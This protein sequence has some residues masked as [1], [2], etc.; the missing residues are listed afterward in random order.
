MT[1]EQRSRALPKLADY[2]GPEP[3]WLRHFPALAAIGDHAWVSAIL[4]AKER[5]LRRGTSVSREPDFR[6]GFVMLLSGRIRVFTHSA[7]GRE[8][9]LYRVGPGD[10][11]L[12]NALSRL[13]SPPAWSALAITEEEV[14]LIAI[15]AK[16]F[17]RAFAESGAFR[18]FVCTQ[19][20]THVS[21]LVRLLEQIAFRRLDVRLAELLCELARKQ[22]PVLL[23]THHELAT[24]L[25][26]PREVV[27]RILKDM[28]QRGWLRRS[29][30][31]IE[32]ALSSDIVAFCEAQ[33]A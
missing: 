32:V 25:G 23:V 6:D 15:D 18:N 19:V 2:S 3:A 1:N 13:G 22:G 14:H 11:C 7:A 8:I 5:T 31:Q 24:Q 9:V 4:N 12:F 20:A 29:R 28:E 30:G 17:E 26:S 21:Y 33:R 10:I 16:H 27:T